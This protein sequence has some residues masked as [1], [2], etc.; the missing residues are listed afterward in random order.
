MTEV[1]H[2]LVPEAEAIAL[3]EQKTM[4]FKQELE[5]LRAIKELYDNMLTLVSVVAGQEKFT[6]DQDVVIRLSKKELVASK[7]WRDLLETHFMHAEK[8][9]IGQ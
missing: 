4:A 1:R 9:L 3:F 6:M 7:S 2:R 8:V 5:Q